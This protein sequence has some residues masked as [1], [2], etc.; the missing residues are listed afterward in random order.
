MTKFEN[1]K[2][3]RDLKNLMKEN[4]NEPRKKIQVFKKLVFLLP[5]RKNKDQI[6][7]G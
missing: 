6:L 4:N 5:S 3:K 2:I 7:Q 1:T